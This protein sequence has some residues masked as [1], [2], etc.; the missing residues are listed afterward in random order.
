[1]HGDRQA[2]RLL[3]THP[4]STQTN[5]ARANALTHGTLFS[6]GCY[7]RDTCAISADWRS[8]A[9]GTVAGRRE[10]S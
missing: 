9:H 2:H 1:M 6:A 5:A 8:L 3:C 4:C 10:R 7:Q